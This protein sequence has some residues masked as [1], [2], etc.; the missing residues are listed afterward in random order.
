MEYIIGHKSTLLVLLAASYILFRLS[1]FGK[2]KKDKVAYSSTAGLLL[3]MVV[4]YFLR[5]LVPFIEA[6]AI[7]LCVLVVAWFSLV[8]S[9]PAYKLAIP[10]NKKVTLSIELWL[11]GLTSIVAAGIWQR[12]Q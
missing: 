4:S 7:G 5:N 11:V 2:S 8:L 10:S 6:V 9:G 1:N 12:V 3:F